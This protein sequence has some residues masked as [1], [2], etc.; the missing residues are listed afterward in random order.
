MQEEAR[1]NHRQLQCLVETAWTALQQGFPSVAQAA[2]VEFV[3]LS[4]ASRRVPR[5]YVRSD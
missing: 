5:P 1:E 4:R 3:E 2:K